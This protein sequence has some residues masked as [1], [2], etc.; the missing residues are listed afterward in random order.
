MSYTTD[1][2]KI[3]FW[4]KALNCDNKVIRTL[5]MLNRYH[6]CKI[7]SKYVMSSLYMRVGR[8]KNCLWTNF[9]DSCQQGRSITFF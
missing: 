4:K 2:R 3:L 9:V 6:N 7:L 5:V 1:Q 8:I